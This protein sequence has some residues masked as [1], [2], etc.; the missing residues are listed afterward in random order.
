MAEPPARN[1]ALVA[2]MKPVQVTEPCP[3]STSGPDGT[4]ATQTELSRLEPMLGQVLAYGGEHSAEFGSYGLVWKGVNDA[5][6]FVS[7][8]SNLAT[9]RA[10]LTKIVTSPDEL[11]VCQVAISGAVATAL[12]A[13]LTDELQGRFVSMGIGGSGAVDVVLAAGQ[14]ALADEISAKYGGALSV[15]VCP[16]PEAC[17]PLPAA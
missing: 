17:T 7:F 4:A 15:K 2:S 1:D 3:A 12:V 14:Q 8:T 5:S 16:G 10:A 11:I 6:V 9:H 13:T